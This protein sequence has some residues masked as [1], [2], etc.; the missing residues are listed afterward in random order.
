MEEG[1][2][3]SPRCERASMER[4]I[5]ESSTGHQMLLRMGWAG[6]GSGLGERVWGVV[7]VLVLV[8][9]TC[10]HACTYP[11]GDLRSLRKL[12]TQGREYSPWCILVLYRCGCRYFRSVVCRHGPPGWVPSCLWLVHARLPICWTR[13]YVA[14][15][16]SVCAYACIFLT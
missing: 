16:M 3:D 6:A 7:L 14:V 1:L 9:Q 15:C 13:V 8:P 12:C 4:P 5:P 11:R 10:A 2:D